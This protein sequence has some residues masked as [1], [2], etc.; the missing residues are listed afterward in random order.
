MKLKVAKALGG[1]GV[2]PLLAAASV[3]LSPQFS[4]LHAK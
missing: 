4:R 3:G 1:I 2:P